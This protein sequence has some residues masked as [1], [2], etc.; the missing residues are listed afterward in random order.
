M[1]T[2]IGFAEFRIAAHK[3]ITTSVLFWISR[4]ESVA[5]KVEYF[6]CAVPAFCEHTEWCIPLLGTWQRQ[7]T[8]RALEI[9]I[10]VISS[11]P[12]LCSVRNYSVP[13]ATQEEC[14]IL[15]SSLACCSS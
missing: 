14:W 4:K 6:A 5:N 7:I 12:D 1:A 3:P 11:L 8:A 13:R 15:L 10:D 2:Q 9:A